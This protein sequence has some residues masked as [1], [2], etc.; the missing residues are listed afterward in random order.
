[1][2]PPPPLLCSPRALLLLAVLCTG[3]CS[4]AICSSS[5]W[6]RPSSPSAAAIAAWS[7]YASNSDDALFSYLPQTAAAAA[8]A[9]ASTANLEY[10][11]AHQ[12]GS[13]FAAMARN[14][15]RRAVESAGGMQALHY[16]AAPRVQLRAATHTIKTLQV[17][18]PKQTHPLQHD[19][20]A[21]LSHRSKLGR[22]PVDG[23]VR[24]SAGGRIPSAPAA[25]AAAN[26]LPS[27]SS[28]SASS[29]SPR[30]FSKSSAMSFGWI[31]LAAIVSHWAH[32]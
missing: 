20:T 14:A 19:A 17:E 13:R 11:D 12:S 6:P 4:L 28:N 26:A 21:H 29:G 30:T 10:E 8:A 22:S 23:G 1:M 27:A 31:T 5:P 3:C 24:L 7:R 32:F 18:S 2:P 25:A 16:P 15:A 9:S